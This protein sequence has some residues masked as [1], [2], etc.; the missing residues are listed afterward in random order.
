MLP[1]MPKQLI[2]AKGE[3][4][5]I[6]LSQ[7]LGNFADEAEILDHVTKSL[8]VDG[9]DA[10]DKRLMMVRRETELLTEGKIS[11]MVKAGSFNRKHAWQQMVRWVCHLPVPHVS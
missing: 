9:G 6:G 3:L 10:E 4:A 8:K 11:E 1:V 2:F 5:A 7:A